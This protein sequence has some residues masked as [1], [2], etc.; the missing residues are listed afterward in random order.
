MGEISTLIV[1][2]QDDM[3]LLVRTY[4]THANRGLCVVGEAASGAEA[5]DQA[6]ACDPRVV[7]LD[8]MMPEMS[9]LET[10]ARLR[11]RRPSQIVILFSAYLD[12]DVLDRAHGVGI[13]ACLAKDAIREL[14]GLIRSLACPN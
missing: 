5:L 2:D 9:G 1:D 7:V 13:D 3:R 12:D 11:A 6:D 10:A 8:E 4:I 14:P